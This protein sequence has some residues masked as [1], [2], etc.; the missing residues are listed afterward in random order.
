MCS[1]II[2]RVADLLRCDSKLRRRIYDHAAS[3]YAAF[4]NIN[5]VEL[6][7]FVL[8]EILLLRGK[9]RSSDLD[10]LLV[11]NRATGLGYQVRLSALLL[12]VGSVTIGIALST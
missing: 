7:A 4:N 9:Q 10:R 12:E 8:E 1:A 2:P 11:L 6:C 3:F 5:K